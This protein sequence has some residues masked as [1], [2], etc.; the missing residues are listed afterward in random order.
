MGKFIKKCF[1]LTKDPGAVALTVAPIYETGA[2]RKAGV[3]HLGPGVGAS[4]YSPAMV[5]GL[6]LGRRA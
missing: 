2:D 4:V 1:N 6:Y 5:G 3:A